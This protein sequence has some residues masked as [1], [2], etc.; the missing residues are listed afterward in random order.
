MAGH[1]AHMRER[2]SACRV[3][4]RKP[5]RKS[6]LEDIGMDGKFMLKWIFKK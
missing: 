3:L 1:V 4:V 2:R 6:H 5:E